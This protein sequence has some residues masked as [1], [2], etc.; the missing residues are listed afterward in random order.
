MG[1]LQ[2]LHCQLVANNS[3][4]VEHVACLCLAEM[5]SEF[6]FIMPNLTS[7]QKRNS[8]VTL[9]IGTEEIF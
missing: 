3:K 7:K 8:C 5:L 6:N 1:A 4:R 2:E 9:P